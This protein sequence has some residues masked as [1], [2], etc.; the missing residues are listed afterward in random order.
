MKDFKPFTKGLFGKIFLSFLFSLFIMSCEK[1]ELSNSSLETANA[2]VKAL[3]TVKITSTGMNFDAPDEIPSGWNTFSYQNKGHVP[4]FFFLA[5]LPEGVTLE[6]YK[7]QVTIP[8]NNILK[9]MRGEDPDGPVSLPKWFGPH[10]YSGGSG[11]IDPGMTAVTSLNL[12][13]GNYLIECYVKTPD[14]DFHS[15]LGMLDEIRVTSEKS[16]SK[17][18]KVHSSID[19]NA[20][21]LYLNDEITRPGSHTFSVDFAEGSTADV[22]LIKIED[23]ETTDRELIKEWIYW[24]NNVGQA[25]EG[26]M[27]PAPDG[28][29]LL[30][31][32]Q[33]LYNGGQAY[34]QAVLKPG[35]YALISEVPYSLIDSHYV[36]FTVK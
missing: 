33:E 5:K 15:I 14:G 8:F 30:G 12:E 4:H 28:F 31:G 10:L 13:E 22:H 11:L 1:D 25:N 20:S 32:V 36:E 35:T 2:S 16:R 18:P 29:T 19:I 3:N 24:G 34:F 9:L 26:L 7:Q 27:T 21:G 17:Q 23:P 6:M